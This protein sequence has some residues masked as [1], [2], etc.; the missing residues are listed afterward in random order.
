L[1]YLDSD[2]KYLVLRYKLI[3]FLSKLFLNKKESDCLLLL[4]V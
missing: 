4:G 3:R 2:T 1:Y